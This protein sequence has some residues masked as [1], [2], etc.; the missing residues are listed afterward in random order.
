MFTSVPEPGVAVAGAA[1]RMAVRKGSRLA[2]G[3]A[4]KD[5]NKAVAPAVPLVTVKSAA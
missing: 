3:S 2:G 1:F 5:A 4:F